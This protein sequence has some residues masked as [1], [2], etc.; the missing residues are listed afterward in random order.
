MM[1]ES[2]IAEIAFALRSRDMQMAENI[3]WIIK[4]FP[5]EKFIVWTANLHGA[6]DVSQTRYPVDS[7]F[8]F[9]FQHLSFRMIQTSD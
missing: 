5:E 1:D 2:R 3:D 7:L 4:N 9:T 8:Y 6:K